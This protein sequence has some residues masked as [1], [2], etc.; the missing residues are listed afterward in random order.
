MLDPG[1]P[2]R[3]A[4]SGA[5]TAPAAWMLRA[6]RLPSC[7]AGSRTLP[8][9]LGGTRG[10]P[11]EGKKFIEDRGQASRHL[12]GP[13]HTEGIKPGFNGYCPTAFPAAS[14][15]AQSLSIQPVYLSRAR[16]QRPKSLTRSLVGCHSWLSIRLP[17]KS[18]FHKA[19]SRDA[20]R[21]CPMGSGRLC[22]L[23]GR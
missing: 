6:R 20:R 21:D 22:L 9:G 14:E 19:L 11:A 3:C 18:L 16:S 2:P 7:P 23:A 5:S 13:C 15:G 8:R 4:E 10:S 17:P 1:P 12:A